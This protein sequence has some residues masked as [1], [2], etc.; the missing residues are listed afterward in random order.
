MFILG[1]S[2]TG[3]SV[4]EKLSLVKAQMDKDQV[5]NLL[6]ASLDDIA[7]LLNLRG[8][9]VDC[10]PVFLSYFLISGNA[11]TLY[12]DKEKVN[13]EISKLLN[14]DSI[15]IKDYNDIAEDLV[16]I[17]GSVV[18]DPS[19]TNVWL[20]EA[21]NSDVKVLEKRNVTTDLKAKKNPVELKNIENAHV[22]D[23]VA[24]VKFIKWV[25]DSVKS[26]EIT[27]MS[28]AEKLESFRAEG[29]DFKDISFDTIAG[30]GPHGAIVHYKA[31]AE[32]NLTLQPKGLFLVDSGAQYL[33]GTTDITRTI[34]LGELTKEEKEDYTL[35]LKGHLNLGSCYI[36]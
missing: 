13:E 12:V 33:D 20:M 11:Y 23:G 34:A 36:Y 30:Y 6:L 35:V 22:K 9:D 16:K 24:M 21:I 32:T 15:I 31:T 19:K 4:G 26:E 5:N 17:S 1:E 10:N 7:W 29:K 3:K 18:F 2:Y 8:G 25:K 28:A 27:E 14:S